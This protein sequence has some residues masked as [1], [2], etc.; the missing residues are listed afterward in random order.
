MVHDVLSSCKIVVL[1]VDPDHR[2]VS[3]YLHCL[4]LVY[5]TVHAAL[6]GRTLAFLGPALL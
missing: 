5:G 1:R 6:L 2:Q 4:K 3:F